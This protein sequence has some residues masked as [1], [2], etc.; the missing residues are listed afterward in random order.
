MQLAKRI[1][2]FKC[3]TIAEAEMAAA[4]GA[5]DVLLA[6][7][8]VGPTARRLAELAAKFP[9]TSFSA[10]FDDLGAAQ[11][12]A[13]AAFGWQL[14]L[15]AMVDLDIGQHRTGLAPGNEAFDLARSLNNLPGLRFLG[16]H[17]Y[18]GQLG[19]QDPAERRRKCDEGFAPVAALV[20]RLNEA[21]V[22][23]RSVVA[24]GSPTFA[25][26]AERTGV[27]LSPGTTVFWD[28]G[29]SAKLPDLPFE[30]AAALLTRVMSKPSSNQICL[31]LGHKAVASEMPHPRVIFPEIPDAVAISHSEEHLVIETSRAGEFAVGTVVYALPWHICPTVALHQ[32]VSVICDGA[33]ASVWPVVARVRRLTV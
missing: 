28:A 11:R 14:T 30:P 18:D 10:I 7:Q 6:C 25:L 12:V 29:Y 22:R 3:A 5:P 20:Q 19:I 13:S 27:E 24:G 15:G 21:G 9:A 33:V 2:K 31:D 32:N 1:Q 4:A 23:V 16:L 26:H 8:P 17:A